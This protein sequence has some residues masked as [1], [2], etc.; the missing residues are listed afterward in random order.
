MFEIEC[1]LKLLQG[2][3]FE[4]KHKQRS[5]GYSILMLILD[6]T[7]QLSWFLSWSMEYRQ[8][9]KYP[10]MHPDVQALYQAALTLSRSVSVG[11]KGGR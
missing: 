2:F 8:P 9:K 4:M 5:L 7:V 11:V 3:S 1:C 10:M 6:F